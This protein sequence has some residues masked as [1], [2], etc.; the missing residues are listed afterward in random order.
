M[1]GYGEDGDVAN[2]SFE[3]VAPFGGWGRRYYDDPGVSRIYDPGA[4]G[5]TGRFQPHGEIPGLVVCP[6]GIR[7]QR[8]LCTQ[9]RTNTYR[10]RITL[11]FIATRDL[12]A[13]LV[14]RDVRAGC[15]VA[16]QDLPCDASKPSQLPFISPPVTSHLWGNCRLQSLSGLRS[17]GSISSWM[18]SCMASL[19]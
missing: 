1:N 3:E 10:R 12:R 14:V 16:S 4:A 6:W 2:G 19:E 7:L 11:Q 9:R 13:V 8:G 18:S 17:S 15:W 5:D